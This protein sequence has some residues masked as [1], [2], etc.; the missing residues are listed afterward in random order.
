VKIHAG[1]KFASYL[2]FG[3]SEAPSLRSEYGALECS[4]EVVDS[5]QEAVQ[6]IQ[7]YGS[8]HTDAIVTENGRA[9]QTR[10]D[11][12]LMVWHRERETW[13]RKIGKLLLILLY[14]HCL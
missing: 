11:R 12:F 14:L 8:S 5:L 4:L 6:H 13:K 1:P 3:P 9:A 2:T 10:S 7:K